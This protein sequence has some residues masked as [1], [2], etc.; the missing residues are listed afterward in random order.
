MHDNA[1]FSRSL[2]IARG[3]DGYVRN[4]VH[5][6]VFQLLLP[7]LLFDHADLFFE[8]V[9]EATE[10]FV[11]EQWDMA[12]ER[13]GAPPSVSHL[14]TD[15]SVLSANLDNGGRIVII[16]PPP[17]LHPQEARLV[18]LVI[19][20][21]A[22][23]T[24][25]LTNKTVS[26]ITLEVT[27]IENYFYVCEWTSAQRRKNHG[28]ELGAFRALDEVEFLAVMQ[29]FAIRDTADDVVKPRKRA[30]TGTKK[31]GSSGLAES[32]KELAD[33]HAAGA[34]TDVEFAAAKAKLLES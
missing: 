16:T 3:P 29:N 28:E 19:S 7:G 24:G 26:Y 2:S 30:S 13:L 8:E 17:A 11:T 12:S 34:L 22:F 31:S 9:T 10:D 15:I 25:K 14:R 5:Y 4:Q 18:G 1:T 23:R 33:L 27:D 21:K 20:P 6:L 32:L